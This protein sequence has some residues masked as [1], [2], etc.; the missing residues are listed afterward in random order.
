M[1]N[2]ITETTEEALNE[3]YGKQTE[4]FYSSRVLGESG[5][6]GGTKQTRGMKHNEWGNGNYIWGISQKTNPFLNF[7]TQRT[8]VYLIS[9]NQK[10]LALLCIPENAFAMFGHT[11]FKP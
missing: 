2:N 1:K 8:I 5:V 4:A 9:K 3:L 11:K 6:G 7:G 10:R